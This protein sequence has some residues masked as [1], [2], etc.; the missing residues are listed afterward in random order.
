MT[1]PQGLRL[2]EIRR[3]LG[4]IL[5]DISGISTQER[6]NRPVDEGDPYAA[7]DAETG[8]SLEFSILS[9][10]SLGLR[11][12]VRTDWD[13]TIEFPGDDMLGGFGVIVCGSRVLT[14]SVNVETWDT[15]DKLASFYVEQIVSNLA[16]PSTLE[17]LKCEAFVSLSSIQARRDMR[18]SFKGKQVSKSGF[19]LILNA[20]SNV[21]DDSITTIETVDPPEGTVE[22]T[23]E[24]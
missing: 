19:D 1:L 20:V 16:K 23:I 4:A 15:T 10:R 22:G 24:D 18:Y 5:S 8:A 2:S 14:V 6:G 11:D 13:E 21:D 9:I 3:G 17:R 12:E 7:P